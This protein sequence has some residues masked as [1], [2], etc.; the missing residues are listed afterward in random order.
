MEHIL[1]RQAMQHSNN[2]NFLQGMD[3][4]EDIHAQNSQRS[5]IMSPLV[6]LI[7]ED[8]WA[9]FFWIIGLHSFLIHKLSSLNIDASIL[10][11]LGRPREQYVVLSEKTDLV[12]IM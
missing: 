7:W 10:G 5:F 6:P 4:E 9:L 11:W 3:L 2:N 12:P 1:Y 8:K